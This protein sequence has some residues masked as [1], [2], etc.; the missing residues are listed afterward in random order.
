[1][2]ANCADTVALPALIEQS[3]LSSG[4]SVLADKGYCSKK[5]W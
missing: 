1:T 2:P 4:V 5:N 3:E